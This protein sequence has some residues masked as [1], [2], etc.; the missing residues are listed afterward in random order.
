MAPI[1]ITSILAT[2]LKHFMK[3]RELT[4]AGLAKAC[5]LGQTTIS[6]YLNPSNRKDTATGREASPTLARVQVLADALEVELWELLRPLTQSQRDLLRSV[7]AVIAEQ[8]AVSVPSK[9][10]TKDEGPTATKKRVRRKPL[11]RAA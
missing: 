4:Q 5:N 10:A 2:N 9:A 7:E 11:K 3:A 1:P 6:L 8:T